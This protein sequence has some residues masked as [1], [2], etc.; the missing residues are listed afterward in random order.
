[1]P[2]EGSKRATWMKYLPVSRISTKQLRI[3]VDYNLL[4]VS[5]NGV[6]CVHYQLAISIYTPAI[7]Y[8]LIDM[9]CK[10]YKW[11]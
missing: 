6:L 2:L 8:I 9:H 11:V 3:L 7:A 4:F 1:M 10:L 5:F